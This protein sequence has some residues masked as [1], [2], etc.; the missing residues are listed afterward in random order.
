MHYHF[1]AIG[2]AV[3]HN[4]ALALHAQGHIVTG[5][6][7]VI[8]EP[9]RSRL[10]AAG[11]LPKTEGWFPD[12]LSAQVDAVI[13]GMHAH[14][15]NPELARARELGLKVYSFPEFIR[16]RA[17]DKQRIVVTGSH[18]KT[19]VTSMIMYVLKNLEHDFD[20]LV[21]AQLAGFETMVRMSETAN[22]SV[23]EGD[24]YPTS[25]EDKR[26]KFLHY[27][28]NILVITGVAWDHVNAYPTEKAYQAAFEQ[29]VIQL[30]KAST[31][32]YNKE[33]RIVRD[34]VASCADKGK[35]YLVPYDTP[36]NRVR[37]GQEFLK[38]EKEFY[39]IS[40]YGEHNHSNLAA[41]YEVLRQLAIPTEVILKHLASFRGAALRMEHVFESERLLVIRD[42]AH[43]P[44]KVRATTEAVYHR[45]HK[46]RNIIPVLELNTYSSLTPDYLG[47]YRNVLKKAKDPIVFINPKHLE[48]KRMAPLSLDQLRA[49]FHQKDL[50]L[51]TEA[52]ELEKRIRARIN[53]NSLL[54]LMSSS[55]LGGFKWES[56]AHPTT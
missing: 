41:A 46:V 12:R 19:T 25:P 44:S 23:I 43:A 50:C 53:S 39:P 11:I 37:N 47:Q 16:D 56:V 21:G 38:F 4:V 9:S 45:F 14:P 8:Y 22:V 6:D 33:D 3:M 30:P 1:I 32:I 35:H 28:P 17:T 34:I 31:V 7:D 20:Y 51:V 13:L 10:A 36:K 26:P 54:L 42:F 2:G 24:E 49:A 27:D 18:G 5:S 29:L 55:D 48:V 15:D 40:I 52:P